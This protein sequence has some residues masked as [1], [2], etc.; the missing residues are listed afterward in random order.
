MG[1]TDKIIVTTSK[2][3]VRLKEIANIA[4]HVRQ[5]LHYLPVSVQFI[6]NEE[7]FLNKV[8]SYARKDYQ[9]R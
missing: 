6:E 5:A 2:D 3:G 1:G 4:V 7:E 8:Y 9:D